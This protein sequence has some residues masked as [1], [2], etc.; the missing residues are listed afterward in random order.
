[1]TELIAV[2]AATGHLGRRIAARLAERGVAQ[3]L[4]VR[5]PTRAPRLPGADVVAAA[6]ESDAFSPAVRGVGTLV[7]ISASEARNRVSL[8]TAAIDSAVAA[9][10]RRIVYVSF[11]GAAADATFTFARDHWHTEEHLRRSG[12]PHTIL[13]DSLYLDVLPYFATLASE[14]TGSVATLASEA[15]GSVA[16]LA[17]EATGSVATLASEAS[18]SVE[19]DGVLRGPAGDGRVAAVAR[20]DVADVAVAVACTDDDRHDGRTYD[21]TGPQ[22][23]TMGDVA[24]ELSRAAGRPVTYHAET[25]EEAYASRAHYGAPDWE[26]AGWVTSYAAIATGEMNVVTDAVSTLAGHAPMSLSDFLRAYPESVAH[27]R[28]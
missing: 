15:S 6:Y 13:R 24:A 18:G 19:R 22:P 4:V 21:L 10:V 3:R 11:L 2:T 26:V 25:L 27:L 12:L 7:L 28:A 5:D 9:G 23:M 1:M 8:H 14:A 20:D 17:S 16:T